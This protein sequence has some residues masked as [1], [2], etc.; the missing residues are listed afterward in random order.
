MNQS[1]DG[2]TT[3]IKLIVVSVSGEQRDDWICV[4]DTIT[5]AEGFFEPEPTRW[6][7]IKGNLTEIVH[8]VRSAIDILAHGD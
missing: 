3:S 1:S 7:R 5:F 4:G 2:V 8:R 6:E